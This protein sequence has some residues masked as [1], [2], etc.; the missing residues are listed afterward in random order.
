MAEL[1][2]VAL[3]S[4]TMNQF[5]EWFIDSVATKHKTSNKSILEI[6]VRY[7][8]TRNIYLGDNTV[9]RAHGEGKVKRPTVNSTREI[10]LD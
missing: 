4:S 2:G 5:N 9:V 3:I 1:E 8:E 10:A 6:Y 7:Q